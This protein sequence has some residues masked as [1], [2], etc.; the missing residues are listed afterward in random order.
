MK[1]FDYLA[2][3][4]PIITSDLPVLHEV[5]N[6]ENAVFC[7]PDDVNQWHQALSSLLADSEERKKRSVQA[8]QD[9][10]R[11][12]WRARAQKAILNWL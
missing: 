11:Y 2:A 1:M 5:L 3:G 6:T 12:T 10:K 7:A 9:A 4:R 8:K